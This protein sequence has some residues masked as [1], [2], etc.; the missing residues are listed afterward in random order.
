MQFIA[1]EKKKVSCKLVFIR[2]TYFLTASNFQK[3]VYQSF[4]F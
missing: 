2:G 1:L 4:T 3:A